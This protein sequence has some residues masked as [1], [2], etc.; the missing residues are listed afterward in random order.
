MADVLSRGVLPSDSLKNTNL[1]LNGPTWLAKKPDSWPL[2]SLKNI[3]LIENIHEEQ[4][5]SLLAA[6]E[7]EENK[8]Y[9]FI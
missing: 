9:T 1:W 2:Q 6:V 3:A 5:I 8:F 4:T 7:A